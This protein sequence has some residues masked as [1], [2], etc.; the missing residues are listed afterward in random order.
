M[1]L[2]LWF[3]LFP[4]RLSPCRITDSLSFHEPPRTLRSSTAALFL[5][6]P[7]LPQ[8]PLGML[9][10]AGT[11]HKMERFSPYIFDYIAVTCY[12]L[13]L[14]S[15][16]LSWNKLLFY[17]VNRNN[18]FLPPLAV[19]RFGFKHVFLMFWDYEL[20]NTSSWILYVKTAV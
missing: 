14:F 4:S 11:P 12:K 20:Q 7:G 9:L 19:Y 6:F 5:L 17:F 2:W 10:L 3:C 13:Y 18:C 15:H 1:C 8:K 16:N